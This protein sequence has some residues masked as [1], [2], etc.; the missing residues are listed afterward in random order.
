VATKSLNSERIKLLGLTDMTTHELQRIERLGPIHTSCKIEGTEENLEGQKKLIL[1]RIIQET[2]Q[3][4]LKHS[5]AKNIDVF[6]S[7]QTKH[8]KI[9]IADN[10]IGFNLELLNKKKGLGLQKHH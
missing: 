6:F 7:F 9:E 3:N 1:F 8:L 4:I 2:I 10:G 5:K